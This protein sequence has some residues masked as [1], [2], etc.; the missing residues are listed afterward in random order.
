[1]TEKEDEIHF[2][3]NY[4]RSATDGAVRFSAAKTCI[5]TITAMDK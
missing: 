5:Q 1:M 4:Y 3:I 2:V